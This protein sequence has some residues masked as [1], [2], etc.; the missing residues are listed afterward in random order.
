MTDA[1]L[2]EIFTIWSTS[3]PDLIHN[4]WDLTNSVQCIRFALQKGLLCVGPNSPSSVE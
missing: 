4:A 2:E 3:R 1:Q